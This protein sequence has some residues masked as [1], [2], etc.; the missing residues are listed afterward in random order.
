MALVTQQRQFDEGF[1]LALEEMADSGDAEMAGLAREELAALKDRLP[2]LE[3]DVALLLAPKD[4][5]ENA[6][7]IL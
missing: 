4:R 1:A 2:A 5:D 7:A 6:S 3:R